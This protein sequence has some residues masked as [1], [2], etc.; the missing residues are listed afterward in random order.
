[1]KKS[2]QKTQKTQKINPFTLIS[3]KIVLIFVC[4][5]TNIKNDFNGGNVLWQL[6]QKLKN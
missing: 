1:M 5:N 3:L 6:A 4:K 2:T